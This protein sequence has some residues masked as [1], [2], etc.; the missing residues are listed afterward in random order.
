[1]LY[2]VFFPSFHFSFFIFFF[3][4]VFVL[5]LWAMYAECLNKY[6][7]C[8]VLIFKFWHVA[9]LPVWNPFVI[10]CTYNHD[11]Q[12]SYTWTVARFN[13]SMPVF[14]GTRSPSLLFTYCHSFRY[15][16][17]CAIEQYKTTIML[18]KHSLKTFLNQINFVN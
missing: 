6:M 4:A 18:L 9:H 2:S 10:P 17:I 1:M 15:M 11:T 7:F 8:S 14:K 5:R 13:N 12:T 3:H 16:I